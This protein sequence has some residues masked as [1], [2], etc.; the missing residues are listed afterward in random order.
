VCQIYGIIWYALKSCAGR[1]S[2]SSGASLD[3]ALISHAR[4]LGYIERERGVFKS[5]YLIEPFALGGGP[6]LLFGSFAGKSYRLKSG[7]NL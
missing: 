1:P 6:G 7:Q 4:L 5:F 2:A 3:F